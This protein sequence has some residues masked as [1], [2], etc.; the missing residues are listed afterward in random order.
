M[1]WA[2]SSYGRAAILWFRQFLCPIPPPHW[3]STKAIWAIYSIHIWEVGWMSQTSCHTWP[4]T[5]PLICQ[6]CTIQFGPMQKQETKAGG[7]RTAVAAA[8][9]LVFRERYSD[10]QTNW[11]SISPTFAKQSFTSQVFVLSKHRQILFLCISTKESVMRVV[12]SK[13]AN[14]QNLE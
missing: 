2:P 7:L 10:H 1:V 5:P 4:G 14:T 8:L 12:S 6:I 3:R 11:K 9:L 13:Q